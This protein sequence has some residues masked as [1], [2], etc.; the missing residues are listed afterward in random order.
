MSNFTRRK[1]IANARRLNRAQGSTYER[2]RATVD[3]VVIGPNLAQVAGRLVNAAGLAGIAPGSVVSV[4]NVASAGAALYMPRSGGGTASSGRRLSPAA[5]GSP[6]GGTAGAHALD[7]PMHTGTLARS[8]APWAASTSDLHDRQHDMIDPEDHTVATGSDGQLV[9]VID[10]DG[11]PA[12]AY[13]DTSSDGATDPG[14]IARFD[15]SGDL[16]ARYLEAQKI[17]NPAGSL[18]LAAS[19]EIL[20]DQTLKATTDIG[21]APSLLLNPVT[22]LGDFT[23]LQADQA[24]FEAVI[25]AAKRAEAGAIHVTK[26]LAEVAQEMTVPV[27]G[28]GASPGTAGELIVNDFESLPGWDPIGG[29]RDDHLVKLHFF[30]AGGTAITPVTRNSGKSASGEGS[31]SGATVYTLLNFEAQTVG[32]PSPVMDWSGAGNSTT[33]GSDSSPATVELDGSNRAL[34]YD[35]GAA[36]AHLHYTGAS[37]ASIEADT[38]IVYTGRF[39]RSGSGEGIGLLVADRYPTDSADEYIRIRCYG[40]GGSNSTLHVNDH[41]QSVTPTGTTDSGYNPAKNQWHRFKIQIDDGET[42][43]STTTL[44]AKFWADGSSEPGSWM[45]DCTYTGAGRPTGGTVGIWYY[46]NTV[47]TWYD[48]LQIESLSSVTSSNAAAAVPIPAG[49]QDGDYLIAFVATDSGATVT[50]PAE[51]TLDDTNTAAGHTLRAYY[52]QWEDGDPSEF[53]W[54][55][56]QADEIHAIIYGTRNVASPPT[57]NLVAR[58][59]SEE[60]DPTSTHAAAVGD[61]DFI[62]HVRTDAP[63]LSGLSH[64]ANYTRGGYATSATYQM[65]AHWRSVT[66]AGSY[67]PGFTADD[68]DYI[69]GHV[70]LEAAAGTSTAFATGYAAGIVERSASQ[71]GLEDGQTRYDFYTL[72]NQ[73]N[74]EGRTIPIGSI[75]LDYGTGPLQDKGADSYIEITT[76]D[77][78]GS[79]YIRFMRLKTW[80]ES[81]KWYSGTAWNPGTASI[82][83][84]RIMQLGELKGL[85]GFNSAGELGITID[86]D[87][88]RTQSI[89][90]ERINF[91]GPD[92]VMRDGGIDFLTI[93]RSE[94]IRVMANNTGELDTSRGYSLIDN[95]GAEIMGL[96]GFADSGYDDLEL[97]IRIDGTDGHDANIAILAYGG[98]AAGDVGLVNILSDGGNGSSVSHLQMWSNYLL[99][100]SSYF[101]ARSDEIEL[102]AD[103]LTFTADEI[104]AWGDAGLVHGGYTEGRTIRAKKIGDLVFL[105]GRITKS[106]NNWSNGATIFTLSSQYRPTVAHYFAARLGTVGMNITIN[107]N[108]TIVTEETKTNSAA[109]VFDGI[110]ISTT[111]T[112]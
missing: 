45:I 105:S 82:Y 85:G 96:Y 101:H 60:P 99:G 92:I 7:G 97:D 94:G 49:T 95:T 110:V 15:S 16:A 67:L 68:G 11:T 48:D 56:D 78:A 40:T 21:G 70:E 34:Y 2:S 102:E 65:V 54:S 74:A 100:G 50:K 42:A 53:T 44:R 18:T 9:G 62:F 75:A 29:G 64:P 88:G 63:D 98:S 77:Q 71:S 112:A 86:S 13:Y 23:I 1:R 55:S 80:T 27:A 57:I 107:P 6:G 66:V 81:G 10:T 22:G 76:L 28:T 30:S 38:G 32:D 111:V 69:V 39:K 41:G 47:G 43:A 4:Q 58:T 84:D 90:S 33:I 26:S 36:N 20:L 25:A 89:T 109:V 12:P 87:D 37:Q 8:Q 3:A 83:A 73:S 104:N 51:F 106:D 59:G 24:Y 72:P 35:G 46:Q 61:M 14:A 5:A 108:G 17:H 93:D 103:D 19:V 79:P 91:D 52:C 31:A